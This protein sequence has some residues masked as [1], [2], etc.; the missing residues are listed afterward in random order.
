[1]SCTTGISW[2]FYMHN[3]TAYCDDDFCR[4]PWDEFLARSEDLPVGHVR[5]LHSN[6]GLPVNLK[7][8]AMRLSLR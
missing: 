6:S 8:I 5:Q 4:L 7:Y 2:A 1:M 3:I